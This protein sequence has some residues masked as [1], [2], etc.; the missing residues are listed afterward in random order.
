MPSPFAGM[1]PFLEED[2]LW[3]WFHH[4]LALTLENMLAL[5]L[6]D[7]YDVCLLNRL[8]RSESQ[9]HCEEYIGIHGSADGQLIT[10]VDIVSPANKTT[11]SG[12]EACLKTRK[13]AKAANANLIEIDLVLQGQPLLD[14]SRE[15]L[16]EWDHSVTVTRSTQPERYEIYT[17]ILQ[18]KLP[19]FRLPLAEHDRDIVVELQEEFNQAYEDG[20]FG[21]Q[22]DYRKDPAVTLSEAVLG[23]IA[24]VLRERRG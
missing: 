11:P 2:R 6:R 5:K 19:K 12:R 1:D 14:Y 17:A 7:P 20:G 21:D 9:D 16:P 18:K 10:L 23:R 24:A 13:E 3:P 22:I 4:H 15:G 8:Y